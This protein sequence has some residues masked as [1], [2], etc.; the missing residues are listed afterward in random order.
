MHSLYDGTCFEWGCRVCKTWLN[1]AKQ[2]RVSLEAERERLWL[3]TCAPLCCSY[4]TGPL[5]TCLS[6]RVRKVLLSLH[7][8][9]LCDTHI[10]PMKRRWEYTYFYLF[11]Y[12]YC[13]KEHTILMYQSS[14]S[15][16]SREL[17]SYFF[18][19]YNYRQSEQLRYT[20][21]SQYYIYRL[22]LDIILYEPLA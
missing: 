5:T 19:I 13:I 18:L 14:G 21:I 3:R 2:T 15:I 20:H 22:I 4:R 8:I 17:R 9:Y 7:C 11:I 12:F 6:I 1:V 16:W 10:L